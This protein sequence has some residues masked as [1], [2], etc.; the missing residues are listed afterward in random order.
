MQPHPPPSLH[1]L[2]HRVGRA[3]AAATASLPRPFCTLLISPAPRRAPQPPLKNA[4]AI[5]HNQCSEIRC[6]ACDCELDQRGRQPIRKRM[7]DPT[8]EGEAFVI[9]IDADKLGTANRYCIE[10]TVRR[11]RGKTENLEPRR[12]LEAI[13]KGSLTLERV[14]EA[15][16]IYAE[17]TVYYDRP[18]DTIESRRK[19]THIPVLQGVERNGG[20]Q[21]TRDQIQGGSTRSGGGHDACKLRGTKSL[22]SIVR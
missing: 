15:S 10:P 9:E 4:H 12:N 11:E 3:D 8:R 2:Y 19:Y 5:D 17:H 13:A 7:T 21:W 14:D 22:Y 20:C 18:S 16:H 6:L 1:D